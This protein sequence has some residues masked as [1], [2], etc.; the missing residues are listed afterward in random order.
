MQGKRNP[1]PAGLDPQILR[2]TLDLILLETLA[3]GP[4][5][6]YQIVKAVN[7]RTGGFFEL[8][9]GSLYPALHRMEKSR[10]LKGKWVE[11]DAGRRRKYYEVTPKGAAALNRKRGT[12]KAF[13]AALQRL[14]E[15]DHAH[16]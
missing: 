10:L 5:Y 8:R 1:T 2:G 11:T 7:A 16:A 15:P 9:E 6:G 3:P 13:S 12:W 14:T 4:M